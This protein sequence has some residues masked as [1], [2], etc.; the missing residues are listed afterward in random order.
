MPIVRVDEKG[1]DLKRYH[2]KVAAVAAATVVFGLYRYYTGDFSDG[3][4]LM[5][6]GTALASI[7]N[8]ADDS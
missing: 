3:V 6:A 4:A 1:K 7:W 2:R 5:L 8:L